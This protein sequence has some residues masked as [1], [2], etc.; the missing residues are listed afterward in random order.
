MDGTIHFVGGTL[1]GKSAIG[2]H[3]RTLFLEK[4]DF[5][6]AK[7]LTPVRLKVALIILLFSYHPLAAQ[8]YEQTLKKCVKNFQEGIDAFAKENNAAEIARRYSVFESCM[9]GQKFPSFKL[10]TYNG[11]KYSSEESSKKVV[12][13][14]F[15]STKSPTSVASISYLNDLVQEYT[16]KEF[17]VLSFSTEET[18][19]LTEFL[20]SRPVKYRVFGKSRDLINHQFTTLLGYP[21]NIILNKN[22]EIV[23]YKIGGGLNSEELKSD[24]AELMKAIDAEL[25][26]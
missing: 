2:K 20:K 24:K 25:M 1:R 15:W 19:T 8:Q 3:L 7:L 17:V 13:L 16:D 9:K 6:F 22:G 18:G 23:K 4:V 11:E 14:N 12:L 10:I 5:S 26:K 21:T